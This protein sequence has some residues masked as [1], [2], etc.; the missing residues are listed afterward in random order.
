MP[1]KLDFIT[2]KV[3][4]VLEF[5]FMYPMEEFYERE[6]MRK[7]KISKGS[8]NKILRLLTKFDFLIKE[9]RGRMVFYKLN[10]KNPVVKQ[11]KI[12]FNVWQVRKLVYE[13]SQFTKKIILFGSCAE[14]SDVKESDIDLFILTTKK[15][16]VRESISKFNRKSERRIVPIIV[17]ANEFV[18]LKKEDKPLYER[19]EK[20]IILWEKE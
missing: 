20:G 8:A 5:F 4:R 19:I 15:E 9:K 18:K 6:I 1:E 3:M 11:F 12:L 7:T 2:P 10:V 13:I 16:L 14:G 17:D